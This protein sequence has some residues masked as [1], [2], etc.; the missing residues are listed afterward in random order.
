MSSP[1]R[2][3]SWQKS[4][5]AEGV[6]LSLSLS[7]H[8]L[9]TRFTVTTRSHT[10]WRA[11]TGDEMARKK[12]KKKVIKRRT[13]GPRS[14]WTATKLGPARDAAAAAGAPPPPTASRAVE[15]RAATAGGVR[16]A[17]AAA[18]DAEAGVGVG[19]VG[20]FGE[21]A[22]GRIVTTRRQWPACATHAVA[23]LRSH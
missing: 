11:G 4:S 22:N 16:A 20:R 8:E 19:S 7:L 17:R 18:T 6:S 15:R 13:D 3:E 12:I 23:L 1:T 10:T 2:C 21:A 14:S 5:P 9:E